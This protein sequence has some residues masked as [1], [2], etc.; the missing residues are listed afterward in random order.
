MTEPHMHLLDIKF[1]PSL[2][3]QH[4][5][6]EMSSF[7]LN[8]LTKTTWKLK[9]PGGILVFRLL[10]QVWEQEESTSPML[11]KRL[12]VEKREQEKSDIGE[13]GEGTG[14]EVGDTSFRFI[15]IANLKHIAC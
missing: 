4:N 14:E 12:Q 10:V 13:E 3:G 1:R 11:R 6:R 15:Y 9:T 7:R 8:L 2:T 5:K